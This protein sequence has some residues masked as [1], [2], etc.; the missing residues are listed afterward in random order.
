MTLF[1]NLNQVQMTVMAVSTAMLVGG[2]CSSSHHGSSGGSYSYTPPPYSTA[3]SKSTGAAETTTEVST[4]TNTVI[5]LYEESMAV[6]TRQVEEG[7]V[8]IRKVVKTETVNQPVQLRRETV[9]I[10]RQPASG[11]SSTAPENAFQE[12]ETTIQLWREE[13]VV[14]TRVVPA[15]QIVA[16][17]HSEIEQTSV[18]RD[19]RKETVDVDKGNAQNVTISENV[20]SPGM[21][22][23][24]DTTIEATGKY[25]GGPITE[26]SAITSASDPSS[27]AQRSVKLSNV[28]V[29]RVIGNRLVEIHDDGGRPCYVRLNETMPNVKEGDMINISGTTKT[30]PATM[31]DLSL[32][33]DAKQAL[34]GQQIF[35]DAQSFEVTNH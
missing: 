30:I 18:Q 26:V 8:K 12:G 13:P 22:G 11:Q 28:R 19:L 3:P 20:M 2:C 25:A 33:D 9:T 35:V 23:S 34:K 32:G 1:R 14:E 6:G 17:R 21:G 7:Q 29:E 16:S 15:G 31:S 27:L 10:E 5:P 4:G 24:S